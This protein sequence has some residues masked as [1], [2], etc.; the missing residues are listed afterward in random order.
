ML[1]KDRTAVI[2]GGAQG[3]GLAIA[4]AFVAEAHGWCW[5][6][7]TWTPP[8]R[9]S[10]GGDGRADDVN[11]FVARGAGCVRRSPAVLVDRPC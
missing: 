5:G 6:T 2:T 10:G 1:L 11:Q 7:S 4:S 9:R 3:I 8:G